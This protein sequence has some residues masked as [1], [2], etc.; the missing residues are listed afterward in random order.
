MEEEPAEMSLF[1][2][3]SAWSQNATPRPDEHA[4]ILHAACGIYTRPDIVD[5]ILDSVDWCPEKDLTDMR[6]LE[7]ACG[8]GAFVARAA[9]RLLRSFIAKRRPFRR[10]DLAERIR[11]YEIHPGEAARARGRLI[12]MLKGH[13]LSKSD[14]Q[15]IVA[16]WVR[17]GDFLRD[18]LPAGHFTHVVGNPPYM[19]WSKLPACLRAEY[20][21]VL[22]AETA[23]GDLFLP[24][25]DRGIEALKVGGYL[26]FLCTDRWKYMGFAE[27]FRAI[28]LPQVDILQDRPIT[29]AEAYVEKA[30]TYPSIVVMRRRRAPKKPVRRARKGLS[31]K[32]AGFEVRVGPALGCTE[33]FVLPIDHADEVEPELLRPWLSPSDVQD[34]SIR[35]ASR[36]VICMYDNQGKL[37]DIER[38]PKTKA[39]LSRHR[40]KLEQRSVVRKHGAVWYRPIDKVSGE[41][42]KGP[43]LLVPE[44]SKTP[45]LAFDT[46]G[47]VPAHGLYSI[48]ASDA[49]MELAELAAKLGDGYFAKEMSKLAPKASGGYVRCYKRFIEM[50]VVA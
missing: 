47:A 37:R 43:K 8:D 46:S 36:V 34:G 19:R 18:P 44:L 10:A 6:L 24:F 35:D 21:Q 30:S 48:E 22:P 26:G 50:L 45:R 16:E 1:E 40:H 5:T 33:A 2:G 28:R 41:T 15:A 17:T 12:P 9:D 32:Q 27:G 38:F 11:S 49:D 29:P 31:L 13:G 23:R 3:D 14:A 20:E 39:W 4:A 25:L 7:P 42:W